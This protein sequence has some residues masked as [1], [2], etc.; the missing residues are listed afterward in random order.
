MFDLKQ[1]TASK[2]VQAPVS[3]SSSTVAD[4]TSTDRTSDQLK[5]LMQQ[6]EEN[7][8]NVAFGES[9]S[10][11]SGATKRK[12]LSK[13][14]GERAKKKTFAK[15]L[16]ESSGPNIGPNA[17]SSNTIP[18]LATSPVNSSQARSSIESLVP[19]DSTAMS[20]LPSATNSGSKTVRNGKKKEKSA[21][22]STDPAIESKKS[23]KKSKEKKS[24]NDV[25]GKKKKLKK[26]S[27]VKNVGDTST[28]PLNA[29]VA[30]TATPQSAPISPQPNQTVDP[31]LTVPANRL[32]TH[33][34]AAG[35]NANAA[36]GLAMT[37]MRDPHDKGVRC[38]FI[39]GS[40]LFTASEDG[41]L[42]FNFL[43]RFNFKYVLKK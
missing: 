6:L 29:P 41:K 35:I 18:L 24:P 8:V 36:K 10:K 2:S 23:K 32:S 37:S 43:F 31:P 11:Q 3:T 42:Y 19:N 15:Q 33:S 40:I 4:R 7:G 9:S 17:G 14:T 13:D 26:K 5:S 1:T 30:S 39:L 27:P 28:Q 22:N 20:S 25:T 34:F 12:R 21:Q 38:M 16:N